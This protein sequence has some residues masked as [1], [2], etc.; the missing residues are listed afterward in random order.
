MSDAV[1]GHWKL[2]ELL[3]VGETV[4]KSTRKAS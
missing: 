2:A 1:K 4:K 3:I